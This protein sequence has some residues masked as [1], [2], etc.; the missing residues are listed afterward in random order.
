L[1]E[2]DDT[3][4]TPSRTGASARALVLVGVVAVL[5]YL[6]DQGAKILAL[7]NL[8]LNRTVPFIGELLQLHLV[9]NAGAA[10]S[11]G[12]NSTW[13]FAIIA[14]LVAIGLVVFAR[15]IRSLGWAS[16]FGLL[17]GG[18]LGNLSDR[19]FRE[20]GFGVGH[21]IDFLQLYGFPAIFNVA[22]VGI[23]SA[24]VL[25]I[26]LTIRGINLDGT[27]VARASK[28]RRVDA[29]GDAA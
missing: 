18:T 7:S 24:M 10:F 17:L 6:A 26:L 29:P 21:V 11:L 2:T 1:P 23:T 8:E 27:R 19:L 12:S 4:P 20:P 22:D 9:K 16:V 3:T 13:V 15:R 5:V 25:F 28:S 14:S